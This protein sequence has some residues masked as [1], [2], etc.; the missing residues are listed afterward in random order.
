MTE[1]YDPYENAVAERIN[2]ILK[3]EFIGNTK[4]LKLETMKQL[5]SNSIRIYNNKRPHY[6]NYYLTPKQMHQQQKIPMRT[7]KSKKLNEDILVE[8]N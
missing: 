1:A 3:Q 7:Y 2:G 6:S 8:L 4:N 5:V